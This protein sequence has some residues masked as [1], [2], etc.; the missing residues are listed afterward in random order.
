MK[1]AYKFT[2]IAMIVIS[3]FIT[4]GYTFYILEKTLTTIASQNVETSQINKLVNDISGELQDAK[5][6]Q[7]DFQLSGKRSYIKKNKKLLASSREKLEK[8]KVLFHDE[9]TRGIVGQLTEA[10][11]YFHSSFQAMSEAKKSLGVN[12][13]SGLLGKLRTAVHSVEEILSTR[14]LLVLSNSMLMMRRHEK[15]YLSRKSEK[16]ITKLGAELES[17]KSLLEVTTLSDEDKAAAS[18]SIN[19]YYQTFLE[20]T[21]N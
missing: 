3:G 6:N 17:F 15:D 19:N 16:Y 5:Q 1:L 9:A 2:A 12:H 14:N 13:D 4:I 18:S 8:L 21:E 20:L 11:E 7:K 10:V